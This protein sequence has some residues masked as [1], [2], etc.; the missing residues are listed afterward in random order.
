[1]SSYVTAA[2]FKPLDQ[3]VKESLC[4]P[5]REGGSQGPGRFLEEMVQAQHRDVGE[6]EGEYG[7]VAGLVPTRIIWGK[8]D[9]WVP[10]ST[11]ERLADALGMRG[12]DG[13]GEGKGGESVVVIEEAG[14]LVM[15]DQPS[16]VAVEVAL[17]LGENRR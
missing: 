1:V 5:W 3:E 14:H 13:D 15:F 6:I 17:W 8:D 7:I 11:A 4:A 10:A 9:A 2:A 16:R 12:R